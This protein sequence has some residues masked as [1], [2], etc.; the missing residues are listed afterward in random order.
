MLKFALILSILFLQTPTILTPEQALQRFEQQLK[1]DLDSNSEPIPAPLHPSTSAPVHHFK[2]IMPTQGILTSGYGWRWGRM[3][4]G[5]DIAGPVGTPIMAA[6][7]GVVV[8]A[9]WNSGGYG[10]LVKIQHPDNSLT[11][12]AHNSKILIAPG[13]TVRQ[14]Q[15]I[16]LMG[17]TGYSTGP[18]LHFEIHPPGK[19]AVNPLAYF[20]AKTNPNLSDRN[21]D[22]ATISTLAGQTRLRRLNRDNL[23]PSTGTVGTWDSRENI[24]WR[25]DHRADQWQAGE[26]PTLWD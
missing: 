18:H 1:D 17:S 19:G 20:N 11:L 12:Y 16:A 9:G 15:T 7:D 5:I 23:S 4:K 8:T 25:H 24:G 3:H 22:R 26:N 6:A 13:D 2:Y 21:P 14:G 10:Y